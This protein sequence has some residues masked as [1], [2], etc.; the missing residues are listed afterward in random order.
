[1]FGSHLCELA[2]ALVEE[3]QEQEQEGVSLFVSCLRVV[4]LTAAAAAV[5]KD[6]V[7]LSGPWE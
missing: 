4:P 5:K 3:Q 1:V 6:E 7:M 2:V